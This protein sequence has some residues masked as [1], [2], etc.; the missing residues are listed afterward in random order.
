M[1]EDA[2]AGCSIWELTVHIFSNWRARKV[3]NPSILPG[4]FPICTFFSTNWANKSLK[5]VW[6]LKYLRA[7]LPIKQDRKV[8][9]ERDVIIPSSTVFW[10]KRSWFRQLLTIPVKHSPSWEAD[11]RSDAQKTPRLLPCSQQSANG[12]YPEPDESSPHLHT[13]FV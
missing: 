3:C 6:K 10:S 1:A 12:P 13:L 9:V 7:T 5:N 11:G 4:L 2:I 8:V